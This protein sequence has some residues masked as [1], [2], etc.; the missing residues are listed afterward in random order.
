[1]RHVDPRFGALLRQLRTGQGLSLRELARVSYFSKSY[2]HDFETGART[3]TR[4]HA[5]RLDDALAASGVLVGM[6]NDDDPLGYAAAHPRSTDAA[7]VET[8][9]VRLADARRLEDEVGAA[10]MLPATGAQLAAVGDLMRNARAP[11]RPQLVGVAAQWAQF[12]GWLHL[13]VGRTRR[14]GAMF[15]RA[16]ECALEVDDREM[17][18]TVLSF[19]GH[20][21][22]LAGDLGPMI[23]LTEA[24]LRDHG[25]HVGQ[26]AYDRY[27]LARGHAAAGAKQEAVEAVAAGADLAAET[28]GFVGPRPPWHYYRSQAFFD[29]EAGLVHQLRGDDSRAVELLQRGLAGLPAEMREAE[30]TGMYR[31]ALARAS[32]SC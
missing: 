24:A 11:V 28:V 13:A 6:V 3:P 20:A 12:A 23:G 21:A 4:E 18:A 29:L 15:D 17:V 32:A 5:A 19:K 16:L 8:L 1:M 14:A 27:Q 26:R 31:T 22:W 9:A 30:W 10:S 25:V 2:L 7:A